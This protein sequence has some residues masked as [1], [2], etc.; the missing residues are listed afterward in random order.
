[1]FQV[2]EHYNVAY[3]NVK[4]CTIWTNRPHTVTVVQPDYQLL[5]EPFGL[6]PL[7][8]RNTNIITPN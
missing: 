4:P 7:N 5:E 2:K 6:T 1:M 3:C 8:N